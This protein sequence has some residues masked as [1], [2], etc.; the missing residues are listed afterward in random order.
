[1]EFNTLKSQQTLNEYYR[2]SLQD[3]AEFETAPDSLEQLA[4]VRAIEDAWMAYEEELL[5]DIEVPKNR[6]EFVTWYNEQLNTLNKKISPL[7]LYLRDEAPVEAIAFYICMEEQVDGSFDDVMAL[8]QLGMPCPEKMIIA[9]NYWDEMGN[10]DL[11][12]VHTTM[13][14]TSADY[15]KDVLNKSQCELSQ[16]PPLACLQNGNILLMWALRRKYMM[17]L[18]GAI[19]L[20]EGS[21]PF[22]FACTTEGMERCELPEEVIAYH[23]AHISIDA[24]HGKELIDDVLGPYAERGEHVIREMVVGVL[25]RY[26]I[27]LEYYKCISETIDFHVNSQ[28]KAS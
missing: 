4:E 18:F 9:D 7:M 19:G 6:E 16:V 17:R 15:L 8:T 25:I 26:R 23:R 5:G 27:A 22:R 14:A 1:M 21:A 20:V 11:D 12:L 24:K 3:P 28:Q 13:F 2:L 10:G